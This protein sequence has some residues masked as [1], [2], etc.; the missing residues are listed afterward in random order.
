MWA[1]G[2]G[3]P[4]PW[5]GCLPQNRCDR[6]TGVLFPEGRTA[7]PRAGRDGDCL[8][9]ASIETE[10]GS[11][12]GCG[13]ICP[14]NLH[15][16][17]EG[18]LWSELS[19]SPCP[20]ASPTSHSFSLKRA[21]MPPCPPRRVTGGLQCEVGFAAHRVHRASSTP[22]RVPGSRRGRPEGRGVPT[23]CWLGVPEAPS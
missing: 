5:A 22:R 13:C 17:N 16:Q 6:D 7:P 9:L 12:P 23:S 1:E 19:G 20:T 4:H 11:P 21:V 15:F 14:Q 2:A 8:S 10:Q 3:H 18:T